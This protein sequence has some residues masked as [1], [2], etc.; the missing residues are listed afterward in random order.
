MNTAASPRVS[1]VVPT[2]N[3]V[4]L[5]GRCLA[6]L[7]AAV[8]AAPFPAEIIV[9]DDGSSDATGSLLRKESRDVPGIRML[10]NPVAGGPA[11]A[12][13]LGWKAAQ[14]PLVAFTDDD[15]EVDAG[16]LEAL[17]ARLETE[18]KEVAGAGGRVL[19]ASQDLVSRYMTLHRILEP[20]ESLRYVVTANCIFRRSALGVAMGFDESVRAPGGEDPGVCLK[21]GALGYR[22]AFEPRAVVTHH[23]RPGLRSF[24]STFYRYGKGCHI[25][26]D[27]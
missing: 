23:F 20:P 27:P 17:V 14:G 21:L 1:V 8:A 22:F 2:H 4:D 5:L 10:R 19:P 13:N 6:S 18:H 15:C 25:V 24:L 9:V 26:M 16:W 11:R 3:R 7:K 12:R